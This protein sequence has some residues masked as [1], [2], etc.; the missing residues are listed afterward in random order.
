MITHGAS[1][2]KA[3]LLMSYPR[4]CFRWRLSGHQCKRR[5]AQT[6]VR[7]PQKQGQEN[8]ALAHADQWITR[9][10]KWLKSP[11]YP[12]PRPQH[13]RAHTDKHTLLPRAP[14][15]TALILLPLPPL[16][17]HHLLWICQP[18]WPLTP[19][20]HSLI[21]TTHIYFRVVNGVGKVGFYT[22]LFWSWV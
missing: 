6:L 3:M 10:I 9:F 4:S 1:V 22:S 17:H 18:Q 19:F 5:A 13:T 15:R 14:G 12:R 16:C 8:R 2:F 7:L 20:R 11:L 21:L